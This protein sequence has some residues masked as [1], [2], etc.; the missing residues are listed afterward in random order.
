MKS[1]KKG[2]HHGEVGK[3]NCGIRRKFCKL[4]IANVLFWMPVYNLENGSEYE[5]CQKKLREIIWYEKKEKR[6]SFETL[7]WN[8]PAKF[9]FLSSTFVIQVLT[10]PKKRKKKKIRSSTS[11][12]FRKWKKKKIKQNKFYFS[13]CSNKIFLN[14]LNSSLQERRRRKISILH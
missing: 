6:K 2:G 5:S 9:F 4:L 11:S 1:H 14:L 7:K 12:D 13:N 3:R 8:I 10:N